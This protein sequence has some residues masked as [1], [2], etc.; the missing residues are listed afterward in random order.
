[1]PVRSFKTLWHVGA[2]DSTHKRQGSYE[3]A[4]LSVSLHPEDWTRIARLGGN[5]TWTLT[6]PGNVFLNFHR[7][8][9]THRKMIRDWGIANGYAESIPTFRAWYYD[10]DYERQVYM[11]FT[12]R[13]EAE[14]QLGDM[15][16]EDDD[17]K[18]VEEVPGGGMRGT[19]KLQVRCHQ[20]RSELLDDV[21]LDLL[22][23]IY[24]E[25][26]MKID[27][28]WWNDVHDPGNLSAPR[29]VI[30]PSAI[31]SWTARSSIKEDLV[32]Y[33]KTAADFDRFKPY[34]HFGTA[35]QAEMRG[36]AGPA[37]TRRVT[38]SGRKWKRMKDTGSWDERVFRRLERQEYDG[39]VYLNRYEG[40]PMEEFDA[41]VAKYG[42]I[43]RLSDAQFKKACPS[44]ADS[45]VV[46]D[47]Y[48]ITPATKLREWDED[49]EWEPEVY[50]M[51]AG[52]EVHH[53]TSM[54]FNDRDIQGFLWVSTERTVAKEFQAWNGGPQRH[55]RV[56]NFV[57]RRDLKLVLINGPDDLQ[58]M[59]EALSGD[60]RMYGVRDF[61]EEYFITF[62]MR[63]G[64]DGWHIPDNYSPGDDTLII[65]ENVLQY[66]STER[67]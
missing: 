24:A 19:P 67:A 58:K 32:L 37:N 64:F 53:G 1:M 34:T 44:A 23:T 65:N 41:A 51:P 57:T 56:L 25:D 9:K 5:P 13:V 49:E 4:G 8:N 15:Q 18:R 63:H 52:T 43:D 17:T 50:V 62:C 31:A 16:H 30:V 3:G 45:Y 7:M 6:K 22:A 48:R 27:G 55:Y 59:C 21:V 26:V 35:P 36:V 61:V 54:K 10:D 39:V 28:V 14:E 38:V 29:G 20:N 47:P 12:T 2:M 11:T 60:S 46:F 66:V 42:D 40:I 33:H